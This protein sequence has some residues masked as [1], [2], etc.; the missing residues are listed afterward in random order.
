MHLKNHLQLSS[1]ASIPN[2]H[3][4]G[5][6]EWQPGTLTLYVP[7]MILECSHKL[8]HFL[9]PSV[10][11]SSPLQFI[12]SPLPFCINI[13]QWTLKLLEKA[14]PQTTSTLDACEFSRSWETFWDFFDWLS[15]IWCVSN[16]QNS[17]I[18]PC[19]VS[20]IYPTYPFFCMCVCGKQDSASSVSHW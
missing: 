16:C 8:E 11:L 18:S 17:L 4:K 13:W 15:P 5:D 14:G 12:P 9:F 1:R 19:Q 20:V 10:P 3:A 6:R 2:G 7:A